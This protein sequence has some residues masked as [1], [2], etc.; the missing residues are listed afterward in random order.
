MD[1]WLGCFPVPNDRG[2]CQYQVLMERWG[3]AVSY[4]IRTYG[5]ALTVL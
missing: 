5:K 1:L 2:G 4:F 3:D